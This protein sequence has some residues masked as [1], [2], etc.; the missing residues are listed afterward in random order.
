MPLL[1]VGDRAFFFWATLVVYLVVF[2]G[3][4]AFLLHIEGKF[5]QYKL[6]K[7][8]APDPSLV[9]KV[10]IDT[11]IG[12]GVMIAVGMPLAK[13]YVT[14]SCDVSWAAL[15]TF[16]SLAWTV[17]VWHIAFDT[18]FYWPASIFFEHTAWTAATKAPRCT[19]TA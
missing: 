15:P 16:W 5:P 18:W 2:W 8:K 12:H 7:G 10:L 1:F 14:T 11:I 13:D 9:R 4:I 17:F 3:H 6:Q 19:A